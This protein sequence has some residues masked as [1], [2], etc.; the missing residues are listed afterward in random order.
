VGKGEAKEFRGDGMGF[1][2]LEEGKHGDKKV[3]EDSPDQRPR[4]QRPK[5]KMQDPWHRRYKGTTLQFLSQLESL[6][7]Q[8]QTLSLPKVCL[9]LGSS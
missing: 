2:V 6:S 1:H 4:P 9:F 7:K 8:K 5:P 3:E